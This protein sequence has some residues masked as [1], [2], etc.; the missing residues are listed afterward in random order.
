LKELQ[1]RTI[2]KLIKSYIMKKNVVFTLF[3][4]AAFAVHASAATLTLTNGN[5]Q[6]SGNDSD[7][8]GW[9][10][11]E[12]ANTSVYIWAANGGIPA[13]T[14]VL[15]M[16]GN[17]GQYVQQSFLT[18]EAT[19]EDFSTFTV[20]FDAGWRG[21]VVGAPNSY[22]FSLVNVTDNLVLGSATY[23]FTTPTVALGNT[24]VVVGTGLSV[25]ITYDNTLGSLAGD[26][27]ALRIR[28]SGSP[29]PDAYLNTGWVDNITVGAVPEPGTALLG[30]IGMLA[31][32]RR[33][34]N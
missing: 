31:L 20:G 28:G 15:A 22:T 2:P 30:G 17:G 3:A 18:S 11:N 19:A 25:N 5:F 13:G 6:G 23:N 7:P 27:I 21:Q 26:T 9:T 34:R 16:W 33:R 14:N 4:L 32:L 24:Y 8:A 1:V 12:P 10:I 29:N